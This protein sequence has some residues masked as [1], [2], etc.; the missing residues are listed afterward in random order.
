MIASLSPIRSGRQSGSFQDEFAPIQSVIRS[1]ARDRASTLP[2]ARRSRS[3]AKEAWA[4]SL[5][6]GDDR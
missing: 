6:A 1:R 3:Q 2:S 5:E 4:S